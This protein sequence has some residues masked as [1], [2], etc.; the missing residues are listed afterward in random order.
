MPF[1]EI[2]NTMIPVDE[3]VRIRKA[4]E[5]IAESLQRATA[6]PEGPAYPEKPIGPKD[7]GSYGQAVVSEED[8]ERVRAGL[9][10]AGL[11]DSDIEAQIV[12]MMAGDEQESTE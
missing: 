4:L 2:K 12:A 5:S 8:A 11:R 10:A 7:I 1:V 3:I 6:L 9:H